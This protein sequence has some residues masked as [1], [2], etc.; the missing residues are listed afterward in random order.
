[1]AAC[2]RDVSWVG[3]VGLRLGFFLLTGGDLRQAPASQ[4]APFAGN[5][6]NQAV[7]L[8]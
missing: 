3:T 1:L 8:S 7:S 6:P 2:V 5:R 4:Y